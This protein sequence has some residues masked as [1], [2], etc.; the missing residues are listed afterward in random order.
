[1]ITLSAISATIRTTI[2]T[3]ATIA[4]MTQL[5]TAFK[6]YYQ[7]PSQ[8]FLRVLKT[9]ISRHWKRGDTA[10]IIKSRNRRFCGKVFA[11]IRSTSS[12]PILE[13]DFLAHNNIEANSLAY[14]D[15]NTLTMVDFIGH[16]IKNARLYVISYAGL[17]N[18]PGDDAL[19]LKY[20][21]WFSYVYFTL[22]FVLSFIIA[23][24][25]WSSQSWWI[26]TVPITYQI[27]Y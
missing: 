20:E 19:F 25:K 26:M 13:G 18:D 5:S 10:M 14:C 21:E 4:P 9:K 17:S 12:W 8:R 6:V 24:V 27:I 1:M 22:T 7:L 23:A 15:G 3:I 16:S 2:A 11:S